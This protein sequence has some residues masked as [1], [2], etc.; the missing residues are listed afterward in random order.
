FGHW[1]LDTVV[2]SRGKSKACV[3]T[4]IERKTRMYVALKI[5]DRTAY[6]MEVAWGVVASQYPKAAFQSATL[7]RGKE[8]ACYHALEQH[9][10]FKVYFADPCSSWQRGA[11]ENGNDLLREF[12]PKGPDFATVTDDELAHAIRLIN[13]RPRKCLSWRS[14]HEAFME[15]VSH[16]A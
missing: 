13:H 3:A 9:L 5:P 12:F 15:E 16:L 8:F 1:E 2:S 6:S 14:A 7:D 11:N 10:G 4:F